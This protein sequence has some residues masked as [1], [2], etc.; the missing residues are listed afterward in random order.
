MERQKRNRK[1]RNEPVYT[2]TLV[3]CEYSPP[4]YRTVGKHHSYVQRHHCRQYVIHVFAGDH[5]DL[6]PWETR[7]EI[8]DGQRKKVVEWYK[9]FMEEEVK[10]I[11]EDIFLQ[12]FILED[13]N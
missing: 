6:F 9:V 2:G 13:I 5:F 11:L 12:D 3:R 4:P 1:N 8:K 10:F 7:E